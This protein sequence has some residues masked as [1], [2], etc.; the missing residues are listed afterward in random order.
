M[1]VIQKNA[2]AT[3]RRS[4]GLPSIIVGILSA[5]PEG[6]F[7]DNVIFDLQAIADA[8]IEFGED[9]ENPKLPQVHALNCLKDIF[10][11]TRLGPETELHISDTLEI[12]TSCLESSSYDFL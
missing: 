3:T 11:D 9:L 7:F 4:A 12:A 6:D 2:L 1:E 10:V 8:P 5:I